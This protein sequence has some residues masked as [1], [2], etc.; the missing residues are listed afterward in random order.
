MR[1]LSAADLPALLAGSGLLSA[2]SGFVVDGCLDWVAEL[3]D[4]HGPVPLVDAADLPPDSPCAAIAVVGS[5][6]ALAELPPAGDE[7]ERA[8]RALEAR[9]GHALRAVLP[10]AAA[11]VNALFP[12]AAAAM[13]GLPLVDCDGMGR[14]LPL[15]QQS[16]YA[17]AG[18]PLTPLAAVGAAGDVVVVDAVGT[19]AD[20]LLRAAVNTAGGWML[21]ALNPTTAGRLP[22]AAIPGA[23]SRLVDVGRV[24]RTVADHTAMLDD[25][26]RVLGAKPLGGGRV[27]ELSH[28]TRPAGSGLPANPV[29]VAIVEHAGGGRLIRL[30][31]RNEFLL[32]TVDGAVAAAVPDL[33]CLLDRRERRVLDPGSVAVGDHV[34]VLVVPAAPIWH[35]PEGLRLAGPGAF[36]FPVGHPRQG[37]GR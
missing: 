3:L 28:D 16:T 31:A 6:T 22:G 18:L 21:C 11:T 13:T 25:L 9:L 26:A 32:A 17:L 33:L 34:D 23:V 27:V 7:P 37:D 24:L 5:V 12:V 29:S 8:V 19:R 15:I 30:E 35:T 4:R 20:P 10:L 1:E 36:G 2:S 14:V